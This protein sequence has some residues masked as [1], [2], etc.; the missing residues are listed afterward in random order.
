VYL[1]SGEKPDLRE[2]KYSFSAEIPKS[3]W[4]DEDGY[5]L[6]IKASD[7]TFTGKMW[8]GLQPRIG[9]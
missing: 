9:I 6:L 4:T 2:N 3:S 8:M 7:V 5:R 1:N